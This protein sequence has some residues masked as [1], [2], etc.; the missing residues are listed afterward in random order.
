VS[1]KLVET[2]GDFVRRV[3]REK[4]LTLA[5]VSDR[6]ARYGRRISAG[7]ISHIENDPTVKVTMDR[8]AALARGLGV[9][10]WELAERA[11]G[12]APAGDDAFEILTKFRELSPDRKA[13]VVRLVDILYS[14]RRGDSPH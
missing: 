4:R 14:D 7:Y 10:V 8:V 3:R 12:I 2:L 13:I 11:A 5:E 9:P 1:L 6:S